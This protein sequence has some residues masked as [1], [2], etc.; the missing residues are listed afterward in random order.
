MDI[1]WSLEV[2]LLPSLIGYDRHRERSM[3]SRRDGYGKQ[4]IHNYKI[5]S[6]RDNA[7][8][9]L[10]TSLKQFEHTL[11]KIST[12]KEIKNETAQPGRRFSGGASAPLPLRENRILFGLRT[13]NTH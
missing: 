10:W 4:Y 11:K 9:R 6:S 13:L 2:S 8:V 1:G 3:R 5:N 7:Y 12:M